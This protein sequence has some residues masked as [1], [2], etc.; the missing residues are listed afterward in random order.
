MALKLFNNT[1]STLYFT[2]WGASLKRWFILDKNT[3]QINIVLGYENDDLYKTNPLYLGATAGRYANRIK[4]G[5]KRLV[6]HKWFKIVLKSDLFSNDGIKKF[7][8]EN[9]GNFKEAKEIGYKVGE[10]L[11]KKAGTDFKVQGN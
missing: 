4:N 3:E 11:L 1:G 2:E 9:S 10:E 5:L 6:V 8:A 7:V